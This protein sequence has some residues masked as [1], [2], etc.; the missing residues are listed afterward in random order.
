[1]T[2]ELLLGRLREV[3]PLNEQ[4]AD[5]SRIK[6]YNE[7]VINVFVKESQPLLHA[8]LVFKNQMKMVVPIK[9]QEAL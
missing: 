6:H 5:E 1:M 4:E 2:S 3:I 8:L 7:N 9:E